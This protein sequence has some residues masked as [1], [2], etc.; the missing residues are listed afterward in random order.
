M[1]SIKR[2]GLD[3]FCSLAEILIIVPVGMAG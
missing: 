3:F 1:Q 2:D